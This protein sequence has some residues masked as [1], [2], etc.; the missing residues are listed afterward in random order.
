M[1]VP[2]KLVVAASTLLGMAAG[3]GAF[4]FVYARGSSYLTND[5][6]ACANCHIMTEQYEGWMKG[7]HH[8][9]ATCNDC[10][11]PHNFVG[12]YMTKARN[13][14]WHSY[15]FTTQTFHEP[16]RI[17]ASSLAITESTCRDCHRDMVEAIASHPGRGGEASCVRC[18]PSVGHRE[19]G[20]VGSV[21][22][23]AG[24]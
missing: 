9:V 4:T 3:L 24:H 7:S 6:K 11:T 8:A 2:L 19:F 5:P 10:H 1:R 18:H 17:G 14:F 16:I 12:K 23:G 13:G 15:Y 21:A 22:G 20:A